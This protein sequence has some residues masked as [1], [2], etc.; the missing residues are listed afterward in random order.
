MPTYQY[1]CKKC[2]EVLEC[3]GPFLLL[4]CCRAAALALA[5]FPLAEAAPAR[6]LLRKR[7]LGRTPT[8]GQR[9]FPS[10][11][12][13]ARGLYRGGRHHQALLFQCRRSAVA[14]PCLSARCQP[15]R[16]HSQNYGVF[17]GRKLGRAATS[18]PQYLLPKDLSRGIRQL[19]DQEFDRLLA[20]V[21]T[22]QK[23]R[24][25]KLSVSHKASRK[26]PIQEFGPPLTLAK[27]NAVRAAFK[28][29]VPPSRIARQFGISR[30]DVREA[31]ASGT[32]KRCTASCDNGERSWPHRSPLRRSGQCRSGQ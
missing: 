30:A 7:R 3:T 12:Q 20:A 31:L 16:R 29:G 26:S 1:H 6:A 15:R 5:A 19:T 9:M 13:S 24:G 22:E 23:R 2:G 25:K 17:S 14:E 27:L 28:A 10:R 21:L 18:S 8:P 32:S 11:A 4:Q